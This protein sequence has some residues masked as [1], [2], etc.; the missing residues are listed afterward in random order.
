MTG[1]RFGVFDHLDAD[2]LPLGAFYENRL[3]LVQ[4]Y[5]RAGLYGYHT[6]E[7]HATPLGMCP[8]PSVL[9][10]AIAQRT[11]TLRFGP[12]VYTLALYHPLRLAEEVCMLD[13]LS[14]GR[15]LLGIGRGISPFELGYFGTDPAEAQGRYLEAWTVMAKAF[16]GGRLTHEGA[17]YTFRDVPLQMTPLQRPHPPLWYGVGDPAAV[18]WCAANRVNVVSNAPLQATRAITDRY[19]EAW[20]AAG[21]GPAGLPFMG[22]TRHTVIAP[23]EG[24]ALDI[25]RRAYARW[26]ASFMYLWEL[27]GGKP[28]FAAY[29]PDIDALIASGRALVGTPAQ[30]RESIRAQAEASGINYLLLRFAFG[31]L[32]PA[33]S[34]RSVEL[35]AK[36]TL[37]S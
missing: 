31:D 37:H 29:P 32:S 12:L 4:A 21:H 23:T 1:L 7:H 15:F 3:K 30:V 14:G 22:T 17:H 24:E 34:M 28:P 13:H 18:P 27:R 9:H 35:F 20:A 26:Y 33:E 16:A 25:A 19:R 36:E 2:G 6:A 10:A 8:S 11:R 5:E